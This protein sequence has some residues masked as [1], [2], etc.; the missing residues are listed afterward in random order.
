MLLQKEYY[1][2]VSQK[3]KG[4]ENEVIIFRTIRSC[5]RHITTAKGSLLASKTELFFWPFSDI[6]IIQRYRIEGQIHTYSL[7]IHTL[8]VKNTTFRCEVFPMHF[9]FPF[10]HLLTVPSTVD[11]LYIFP[12]VFIFLK[13]NHII[14]NVV[15]TLEILKITTFRG[16]FKNTTYNTIMLFAKNQFSPDTESSHYLPFTFNNQA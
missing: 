5:R 14:Q 12:V 1:S 6:G 4:E 2:N 10:V 9:Q 11:I 8:I 13:K 16:S 7:Q 15:C 3:A